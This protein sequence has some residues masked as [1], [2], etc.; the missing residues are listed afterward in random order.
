MKEIVERLEQLRHEVW[1]NDV[2]HPTTPEYVELH[3][4]IQSILN[5]IDHLIEEVRDEDIS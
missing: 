4:K 5:S 2:P 3:E 1:L